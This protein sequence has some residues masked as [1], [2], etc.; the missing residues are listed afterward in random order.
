[1]IDSI[2]LRQATTDDVPAIMDIETPVFAGEA[3]SFEAMARDVGCL[4][5]TSDAADE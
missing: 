3:W 4:L 2:V 1:M 5:Y